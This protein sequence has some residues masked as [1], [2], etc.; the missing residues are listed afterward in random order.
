MRL[1]QKVAKRKQ[2]RQTRNHSRSKSIEVLFIRTRKSRSTHR[3]NMY[4]KNKITYN[5][6][7]NAA[8]CPCNRPS[9]RTSVTERGDMSLIESKT[10]LDEFMSS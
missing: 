1:I 7:K 10:R 5:L 9:T 8:I 2:N 6:F 3:S 4:N